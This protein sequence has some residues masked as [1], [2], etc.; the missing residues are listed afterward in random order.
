MWVMNANI[1]VT[2][3]DGR[4]VPMVIDFGIA[5]A[6]G[7][8]RL[9]EKTLFTS[10]EQFLGTPAYMSPEQAG[11]GK[12][13]I[14]TRSDI[15]SLGVLLYELLTGQ[16]PFD[17]AELRKSAIDEVFRVIRENDPPSPSARLTNLAE[18]ELTTAA[19]H[20]QVEPGALFSLI[21]GDLDHIVMKCLEKDR[22]RRYETA[23]GMALDVQRHLDNEAISARPPS[24]LYKFQKLVLRNKLVFAGLGLIAAIFLASSIIVWSIEREARQKAEDGERKARNELDALSIKAEQ[25]ENYGQLAESE[26]L[27][28]EALAKWRKRGE[29]GSPQAL[30]ELARLYHIL[31]IQTRF[32]EAEQVMTEAL[33]PELLRQSIS[34]DFLDLKVDVLGHLGR[35]HEASAAATRAFEIQPINS[36][37]YS[38]VAALLLKTHNR[39]GYDQF[40]KRI[41]AMNGT[42]TNCLVADAVAKSCLFAPSSEVDLNAIGHVADI[43]VTFGVSDPGAMPFFQVCKALSEYRLG[44]F[45]EAAQWAQKSVESTRYANWH[46]CGVLAMAD[47]QLGKKDDARAMLARGEK[48]AP[49]IMP[50]SVAQNPGNDWL[51]WLYARIQLDEATALIESAAESQEGS[52]KK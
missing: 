13:D 52:R 22:S 43:T 46:A 1:L 45:S 25:L 37:R 5:K 29:S 9:T 28:R 41:F 48:L 7:D 17:S 39:T 32:D 10:F 44:H 49:R 24:S 19:H 31:M 8:L 3:R 20:R 16:T 12:L 34:A 50:A 40:C 30:D 14:D 27:T 42:I 35:W 38:M 26:K 15:Y 21:R 23:N 4:P 51:A 11:L 6:A 2:E 18:N 33:T 36:G 47:W